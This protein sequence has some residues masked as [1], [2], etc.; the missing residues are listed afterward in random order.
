MIQKGHCTKMSAP[1]DKIDG[2]KWI[3]YEITS[4]VLFYFE[5]QNYYKTENKLNKAQI[6]CVAIYI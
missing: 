1:R 5:T 6:V 2:T 4:F 3:R